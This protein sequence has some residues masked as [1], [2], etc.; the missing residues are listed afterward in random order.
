ML[1]IA[2]NT[3][4]EVGKMAVITFRYV[5]IFILYHLVLMKFAMLHIKLFIYN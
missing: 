3:N 1:M 4:D 5:T 2:V